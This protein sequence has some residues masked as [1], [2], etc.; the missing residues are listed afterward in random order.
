MIQIHALKKRLLSSAF[1]N[2]RQLLATVASELIVGPAPHPPLVAE[3]DRHLLSVLRQNINNK[4][5]PCLSH[6]VRDYLSNS[7]R[8]LEKSLPYESRPSN[9]RKVKFESGSHDGVV[10]VAHCV[11]T[12]QGSAKQNKVVT[13]SG[14]VIDGGLVVTGAHTLEQV[15]AHVQMH[16][17]SHP[18][19][20]SVFRLDLRRHRVPLLSLGPKTAL[21]YT[22][23]KPLNR[24]YRGRTSCYCHPRLHPNT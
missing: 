12:T 2:R 9:E 23:W 3:F 13:C 19:N 22:Q 14:F 24:A 20:R 8:I 15:R 21:P 1:S 7:G 10:M 18:H 17:V 5:Q 4:G 16:P 11:E 6:L